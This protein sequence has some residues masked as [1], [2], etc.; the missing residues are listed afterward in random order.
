M[1]TLYTF[2]KYLL[3]LFFI[4]AVAAAVPPK[5]TGKVF[6]FS[7]SEKQQPLEF[8][9]VYWAGSSTV[10]MTNEKGAFSI[11]R[12]STQ[13]A[14]LVASLTGYT[15]DT[16]DI[17]SDVEEVTFILNEGMMLE[18][19]NVAGRKRGGF[20]SKLASVKSEVITME[21][22]S[23]MAC[24]NLA[25]SFE[26]TATISVG[27]SDAV[28]GA[29]QIR[30]LG[31]AGTYTQMLDENIPTSI[32]LAS[33]YG[34]SYTPGP[35]LESIQISKGTTS[36]INGYESIA[37]Q[38]NMEHRKPDRSNPLFL[39]LFASSEERFEAN[40]ISAAQFNERLSTVVFAH[41]S[42]DTKLHDDN[43]DSFADLPKVRQLNVGN[44]WLYKMKNDWQLRFG[45]GFLDERREG[46]QV[47][48]GE[49]GIT[50]LYE[51]RI[52]NRH[53]NAYAKLGIPFNGKASSLGWIASYHYHDEDARYG[54]IRPN[55]TGKFFNGNES[56][57]FTNL[58]FQSF[59]GGNGQHKYSVGASYKYDKLSALYNDRLMLYNA[60]QTIDFGRDESTVG[61]FAEYTYS[62][63]EHLNV[64]IGARYDYNNVY[65][66]L[67]TPRA[68]LKYN[69]LENSSFRASVG[70]GYRSAY[71]IPDNMGILANSRQLVVN[72]ND[73]KMEEAR[74][75][76]LSF[77]QTFPLSGTRTAMFS[78]DAFRSD[79]RNQVVVDTEHDA[80]GIYV[81]NLDGDSYANAFQIDF[82]ID[83][84]ERFTIFATFRYTDT[85][86]TVSHGKVEKPLI[87]R[88]K[89]LINLA[90]ATRFEK[91]KFDF[92]AQLN[93]K[94]R[95]PTR[96]GNMDSSTYSEVY[97]MFYAQVTRKFKRLDIYV[98]AEN[99]GNYTQKNPIIDPQNPFGTQFDASTVWGPLMG[100]KFYM[101]IRLTLGQLL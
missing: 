89:G 60:G 13:N 96:D 37:G 84:I 76:G 24:C 40:A 83:P 92:T 62:P 42:A 9:S 21:G 81:Y 23:K 34:L 12:L 28:S 46:G 97:P 38:I 94:S 95:I 20:I 99:I 15:S 6:S 51:T 36:V 77:T 29:R 26:N 49:M 91:W 68:H 65:G 18:G 72:P 10:V 58:I 1:K 64:I 93:G 17:A 56:G 7:N 71:V 52:D 3:V 33:T 50:P 22:L 47:S 25:E 100:R 16:L 19:A 57:L 85:K 101:G 78:I 31:L 80:F 70:R 55:G 54:S 73:L 53:F 67:F 66:S 87:D 27:Y 88:Y 45:L 74:T 82:S 35:W 43:D 8:A 41:G 5:I 90:Y 75:Y 14:K 30:M 86:I 63:G 59:F 32:G 11:E 48:H 2:L 61:T 79:F 98:G 39:N 44:R 69:F 4:P